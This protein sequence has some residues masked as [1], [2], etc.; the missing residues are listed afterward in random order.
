MS[1]S[2]DLN[3]PLHILVLIHI[4]FQMKFWFLS[5]LMRHLLVSVINTILRSAQRIRWWSIAMTDAHAKK[6]RASFKI[7]A[8]LREHEYEYE[9][10]PQHT[11]K[12]DGWVRF[13][14]LKLIIQRIVGVL[15]I[16]SRP[17]R[18]ENSINK[19]TALPSHYTRDMIYI[20]MK[21]NIKFNFCAAHAH[22]LVIGY[23]SSETK[24]FADLDRSLD[25]KTIKSLN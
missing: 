23:D 17:E 21:R 10:I 19:H 9:Y 6:I 5:I 12:W 20:R 14:C 15:E 18:D 11:W 25:R 3:F 24:A 7:D 22:T 1:R 4:N 13:D 16:Y 8:S 2:N